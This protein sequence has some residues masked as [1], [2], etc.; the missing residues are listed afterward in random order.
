MSITYGDLPNRE[1]LTKLS[2][3]SFSTPKKNLDVYR[4]CNA[5]NPHLDF[6][7]NERQKLLEKYGEK[8]QGG[9]Y[10]VEVK[11]FNEAMRGIGVLEVPDDIPDHGL[12]EEDF[13]NCE[14]PKAKELWLN[15][16]DIM[17]LLNL[18]KKLKQEKA[19]EAE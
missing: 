10:K 16:N 7:L 3:V 8:E 19:P 15:A 17:F 14:Y 13:E 4:F 6:I 5:V 1:L 2:M 11:P 18:S 12:T 9:T